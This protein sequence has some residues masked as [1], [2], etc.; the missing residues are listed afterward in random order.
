[1][2]MLAR[3]YPSTANAVNATLA[4]LSSHLG[5]GGFYEF[6]NICTNTFK[7]LMYLSIRYTHNG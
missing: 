2:I 7:I 4:S 6:V 3:I 1:M 5:K